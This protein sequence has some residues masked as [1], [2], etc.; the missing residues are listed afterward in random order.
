MYYKC[1]KINFKRYGS[2]IDSPEWLQKKKKA[3]INQKNDEDRCFQHAAT[4]TLD[5]EKI[6]KK[7]KRIMKF[8]PFINKYSWYGINFASEKDDQIKFEKINSIIALN[9]LREKEKEICPAYISKY[10]STREK[11][12]SF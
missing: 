4:I 7:S 1:H 12:L 9:V 2:Y 3:T 11:K 8:Y 5:Y 6:G 10:N